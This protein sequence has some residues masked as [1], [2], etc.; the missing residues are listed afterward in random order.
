V[1]KS[2]F[3]L[4]LSKSMSKRRIIEH[5]EEEEEENSDEISSDEEE[6]VKPSKL[7]KNPEFRRNLRKNY[8]DFLSQTNEQK[9]ELIKPGNQKLLEMFKQGNQL[10]KDVSHAREGT[11]DAQWLSQASLCGLE[12][13]NNI[14]VGQEISPEQFLARLKLKYLPPLRGERNQSEEEEFEKTEANFD[15]NKMGSDVAKLFRRTPTTTFMNGPLKVEVKT[16][17]V[18]P[19]RQKTENTAATVQPEAIEKQETNTDETTKRVAMVSKKLKKATEQANNTGVPFVDVVIDP[20]SFTHSIENM[21]YYGFLIKDGRASVKMS[22]NTMT[23]QSAQP[24]SKD[25]APTDRKQCVIKLNLDMWKQLAQHVG[26]DQS[27][28]S[29]DLNDTLLDD[30]VVNGEQNGSRKRKR[31]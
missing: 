31:V 22:N 28:V 8:I 29:Q 12:Q 13:C 23:T 30:G 21:F 2:Q 7:Q 20:N 11:L 19:R 27:R 15:W 4:K 9:S 16:K 26:K 6:V 14:H 24:V 3:Y 10:F 18:K 25:D 5:E 17:I 1:D